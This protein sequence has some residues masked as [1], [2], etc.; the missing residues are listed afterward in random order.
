CPKP[1]CRRCRRP[2]ARRSAAA[3]TPR[4]A[5]TCRSRSPKR[6]ANPR[7]A[8][9]ASRAAKGTSSRTPPTKAFSRTG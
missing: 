6:T 5:T 9:L 8:T 1:I 4:P 7:T 3:P 2:T